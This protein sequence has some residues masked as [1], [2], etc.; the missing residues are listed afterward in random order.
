[1]GS[2]TSPT[3]VSSVPR[4]VLEI[5]FQAP[6]TVRSM[7]RFIYRTEQLHARRIAKQIEILVQVGKPL[8][9]PLLFCRRQQYFHPLNPPNS[10]SH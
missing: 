10:L 2:P 3:L 5:V 9:G 6:Q 7:R 4:Q 8:P 1:V